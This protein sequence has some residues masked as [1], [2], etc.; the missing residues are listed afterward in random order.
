MEVFAPNTRAVDWGGGA[1]MRAQAPFAVALVVDDSR[2]VDEETAARR[3][4]RPRAWAGER[5]PAPPPPQP[6]SHAQQ[7][8]NKVAVRKTA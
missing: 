7:N 5:V 8:V 1:G 4:G 3:G 6:T 2:G